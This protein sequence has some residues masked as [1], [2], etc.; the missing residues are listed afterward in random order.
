MLSLHYDNGSASAC[1]C[2]SHY[3]M[4]HAPCEYENQ[5][6]AGSNEKMRH[7]EESNDATHVLI[8]YYLW[9]AMSREILYLTLVIVS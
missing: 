4:C 8:N 1:A 3:V 6:E 7:V 5:N 9:V 2:T